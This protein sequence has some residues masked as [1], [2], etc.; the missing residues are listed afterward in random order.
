MSRRCWNMH[1]KISE[2]AKQVS[3]LSVN[4]FVQ[5]EVRI[6]S[7]LR[8]LI[9]AV[10]EKSQKQTLIVYV[11]C[12][13]IHICSFYLF[14]LNIRIKV[15]GNMYNFDYLA[16]ILTCLL[17]KEILNIWE[18]ILIRKVHYHQLFLVKIKRFFIQKI[19]TEILHK[20]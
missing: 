2:N 3:F 14:S 13:K 20:F 5:I 11:T 10:K 8:I 1:F 6:S 4:L 18:H 12:N 19:F 9:S 7:P 17:E 16:K 15:W